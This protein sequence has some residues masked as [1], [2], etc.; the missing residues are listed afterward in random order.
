MP[1]ASLYG[2][3]LLFRVERR[4]KELSAEER[5]AKRLELEIPIWNAFWSWLETLTPLGGSLLEK[6]VGYAANHRELLGNYLLDGRC[7]I[8][9]NRA[10]RCAKSYGTGR[11][12]FLFHDTVNGARSSAILYSLVEAAKANKINRI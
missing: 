5:K 6:A 12:N 8:S 3:N 11:W 9:N 7:E 2:K 4:L 10:E 1:S